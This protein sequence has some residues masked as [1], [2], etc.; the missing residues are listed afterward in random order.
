MFNTLYQRN[1]QII[2][3]SDRPPNAIS[4]LEERLR[5]RFEGGMIADV[6]IPDFET[7]LVILKTK[8]D[9]KEMNVPEEVLQEIA[10]SIKTNIRELEGALNRIVISSKMSNTPVTVEATRKMIASHTNIPKKLLSAKKIIKSVADFYEIEEKDLIHRSRKKDIVKPRQIAM[11]FLREELK[12]SY[13]SIGE[14]FGGRDHTT[15][16]HS[17]EKV[18]EDMRTNPELEEEIRLIRDRIYLE[19]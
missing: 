7:R 2:I 13:P 16:I 15:A 3:S 6:G 9:M 17:C 11:Y 14:R 12:L 4:T 8:L 10:Q 19:S 1:K 5:S 18:G